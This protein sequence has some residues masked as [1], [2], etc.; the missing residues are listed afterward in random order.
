MKI[1]CLTPIAPGSVLAPY[2]LGLPRL[3]SE[4]AP[5]RA[6][7]EANINMNRAKLQSLF[8]KVNHLHEYSHVLLMD[9]DV[10]ISTEA[11][12]ALKSAWKQ[13]TTPCIRTKN[14]DGHVVTSCALVGV[15]DYLK[16][17]YLDNINQCQCHKLPKPF[18][19][20]GFKGE[21]L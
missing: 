6:G 3:V 15:S 4:L 18:Y 8:I 16:V 2:S 19:V 21:E 7:R 17:N 11:L 1:L 10:V 20:E 13:E 12:E 5:I 9:S 14:G